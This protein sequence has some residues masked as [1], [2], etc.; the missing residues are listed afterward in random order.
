MEKN[1]IREL[2]ENPKSKGFVN[3]LIRAYL[4]VYKIQKLWEFKKDQKHKCNICGQKLFDIEEGFKALHENRDQISKDFIESLKKQAEGKP[5]KRE[6]NPF[7]KAIGVDK[8]QAFT[9][10]K[11]DTALCLSCTNKLVEFTTNGLLC[12]DKNI[13]YQIN[14]MKR[15]KIFNHFIESPAIDDEAKKEVKEMKKRVDKK[16]TATFGDLEVLQKLKEKMENDK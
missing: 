8:V 10:E 9:G 13:N 6:D 12:G 4:P 15:D 2:Y 11:T 14:Q 16:K 7:V 1:K 5:E 3:H